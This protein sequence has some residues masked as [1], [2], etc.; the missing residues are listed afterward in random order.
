MA[1]F[2]PTDIV[3]QYNALTPLNANFDAIATLLELCVMRDG[4]SPNSMLA[5]IDMNNWKIQNLAEGTANTDAVTKAQVQDMIT[6]GTIVN[7][8]LSGTLDVSGAATLDTTLGVAGAI[9]AGS[10]ITAAGGVNCLSTLN[11]NGA[12]TFGSTVGITGAT[13][14]S[15]GL[16]G[17]TATFSGALSSGAASV[18]S[19]TSTGNIVSSATGVASAGVTISGSGNFGIYN[20]GAH[21]FRS[22]SGATTYASFITSGVNV[23]AG[24]YYAVD[25]NQVVAGRVTGWG[26]PTGT[27]T[28]T[29][30]DTATVTLPELAQAVKALI[31]DLRSHGLIGT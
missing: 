28:R 27:S 29:G 5:N 11:A 4:T 31:L 14:L 7:L 1:R 12:V 18:S 21:S 30:F 6:N 22:A 3:S 10:T 2:T 23:P 24:N 19:L 9:S 17:T 16:T 20:A 8:S 15:A 13:T 26:V 25:G